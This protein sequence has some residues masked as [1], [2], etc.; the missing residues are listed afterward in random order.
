MQDWYIQST[1][2]I[3]SMADN[4]KEMASIP[5]LLLD[6]FTTFR[7]TGWHP[8]S[9]S[10]EFSTLRL[11]RR[12]GL[13]L[14]RVVGDRHRI[15]AEITLNDVVSYV[16]KVRARDAVY[17]SSHIDAIIHRVQGYRGRLRS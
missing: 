10:D 13:F 4:V 3:I 12:N 7:M 2:V 15:L 14:L 17:R 16:I 5:A 6:Q 11:L 9:G 8:R 1:E